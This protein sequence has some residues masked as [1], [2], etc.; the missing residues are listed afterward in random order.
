MTAV[1]ARRQFPHTWTDMIYMNHAAISPLCLAVR[2]AV[3]TYMERRSLEEIDNIPYG[4]RMAMQTRQLIADRLHTSADRIAFVMNT[5]DGLNI[6][7]AGLDWKPTDRI[8]LYRYEYPAN[9]YPFLA[10]TRQ[11][12]TIDFYDSDDQRITAELLEKYITPETRLLS[13]SAVQFSTGFRADLEIIGALCKKYGIIFSVDA[14]QAFPY[15]DIDVEKAQ[16][17]FLSCGGHKWALAPEGIGFI[18]V[19]KLLQDKIEQQWIGATSVRDPAKYFEYD[20]TRLRPQA[21]RYENGTLNYPGIIGLK[22]SLE[23]FESIGYKEIEKQISYLTSRFTE[24]MSQRGVRLVSST[25]KY[26][27]SAIIVLDIDEPDLRYQRLK[28]QNIITAVRRGFIRL[29]PYFYM[30]EEEIKKTVNILFQ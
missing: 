10:R 17:D 9:V 24:L 18:Y 22:A 5:A 8:L 13:L 12:V 25:D 6:L 1:D 30:T 21:S 14:I 28:Q 7:A 26:E 19:S 2:N 4:P 23:L 11:G 3:D 16:I 20:L 29:S 15:L 27:Q